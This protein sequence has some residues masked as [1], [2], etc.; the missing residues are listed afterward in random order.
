MQLNCVKHYKN[1]AQFCKWKSL[2]KKV[3]LN[4][5]LNLKYLDKSKTKSQPNNLPTIEENEKLAIIQTEQE[6]AQK[7]GKFI[8]LFD[9]KFGKP[10]NNG[11]NVICET[12][13]VDQAVILN[14]FLYVF[15]E[16][17]KE[18]W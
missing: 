8:Q 13:W 7:V 9:S 3:I 12:H 18:K 14:D 5:S 4:K 11:S 2:V 15:E 16:L 6:I 1:S 10:P 17:M